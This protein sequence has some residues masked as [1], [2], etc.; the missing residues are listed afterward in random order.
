MDVELVHFLTGSERKE[1]G[2][3]EFSNS[4]S[5]MSPVWLQ[6]LQKLQQFTIMHFLHNAI[7]I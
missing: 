5:C 7:T 3:L 4:C 1:I 6:L 2:I